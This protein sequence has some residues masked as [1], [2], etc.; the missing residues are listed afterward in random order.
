[1]KNTAILTLAIAACAAGILNAQE[2]A[3]KQPKGWTDKKFLIIHGDDSGMCHGA[4][5]GT[6]EAMEK[7]V[8]T[9]T[10]IMI[11]CPWIIEMIEWSKQH[12]DKDVGIHTTMTAEW[13]KYRWGPVAGRQACRTLCDPKGFM[14]EGV[15]GVLLAASGPDVETELKAQIDLARKLGLKATHADNHMG[16]LF[17]KPSV[18]EAY[19]KVATAE[20]L[21]P[22]MINATS[23]MLTKQAPLLRTVGPIW[24]DKLIETGFP[25]LDRL[26]STEGSPYEKRKENFLKFLS[27]VQPGLTQI[28]LHAGTDSDEMKNIMGSWEG[29]ANDVRLCLDPDIKAAIEANGIT[30]TTWKE[31]HELARKRAGLPPLGETTG[32]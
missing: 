8:M 30:L 2:A 25:V 6:I 28:I 5:V 15:E 27:T 31:Q 32:K 17:A 16:S 10:S 23:D 12:P 21:P 9:S 11:P 7:G 14:W 13:K 4:N 18:F 20:N 24:R 19:M 29:R 22:M 26:E 1:M 3:M